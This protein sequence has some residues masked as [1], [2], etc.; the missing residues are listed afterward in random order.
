MNIIQFGPIRSGT[1][2]IYNILQNIFDTKIVKCH[3]L[4]NG[5][6]GVYVVTYRHPFDCII[7]TIQ[8]DNLEVNNKN[9]IDKTNEYLLQ[10]G[11][12][13]TL[14]FDGLKKG[15][16]VVLLKYESFV[17]DFDYIY[18]K[19]EDFFKMKIPN[20]YKNI[21]NQKFN[22]NNVE[23]V[24]KMFKDF[25]EYDPKTNW[26]GNHISK[27]KGECF[28]YKKYLSN[29]QI[30]M[31]DDLLLKEMKEPYIKYM[32]ENSYSRT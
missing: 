18:G 30:K 26:H 12:A 13:I 27:D 24:T 16:N 28:K 31:I 15:N 10:G 1:T 21:F 17:N 7:S 4:Y 6:K 8:R 20:E 3:Q 32:D 29:E 23:K 19:I 5:F 9:I 11:K 25:S 2:L 14:A 22:I